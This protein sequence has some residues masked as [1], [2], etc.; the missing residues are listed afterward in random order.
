MKVVMYTVVAGVCM[1]LAVFGVVLYRRKHKIKPDISTPQKSCETVEEKFVNEWAMVLSEQARV[2]N[3][4]FGGLLRVH[5]GATKRPEKTLREWCQRTRHAFENQEVDVLCKELI[6][7]LVEKEDREGL[8]KWANLL[9]EAASSA[10]ITKEEI[11]NVVLKEDTV[12]AYV[13]WDGEELN[14]ED[15][16]EIITPAWYQNGEVLEQGQCKKLAGGE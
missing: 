7:P 15:K 3:G 5:S 9:L 2:F 12:D 11:T 6:R 14:P 8:I 16:I 10:G 13:E 1:G 4:L